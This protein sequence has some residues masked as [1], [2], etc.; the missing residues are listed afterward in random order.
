MKFKDWMALVGLLFI[1]WVADAI[2]DLAWMKND[3]IP[4]LALGMSLVRNFNK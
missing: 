2:L 4:A 3:I 1:I